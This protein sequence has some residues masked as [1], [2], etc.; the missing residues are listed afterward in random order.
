MQKYQIIFNPSAYQKLDNIFS[1]IALESSKI[2]IKIIDGIEKQIMSLTSITERFPVVPEKI[3]YK[4]Y[5]IRHFFYKKSFRVIYTVY[6]D[7]VHIL[8]IRHS[9]Q[10]YISIDDIEPFL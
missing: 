10:D 6:D 9:A 4:S 8:D 2:A 7:I 1:Y 3:T 5:Q